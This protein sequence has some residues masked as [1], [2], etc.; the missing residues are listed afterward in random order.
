MLREKIQ[1]EVDGCIHPVAAYMR[2][3]AP[4]GLDPCDCEMHRCIIHEQDGH[5]KRTHGVVACRLCR[6][7]SKS[8]DVPIAALTVYEHYVKSCAIECLVRAALQEA[9]GAGL[10]EDAAL[11]RPSVDGMRLRTLTLQTLV[12]E[13]LRR[14]DS[15]E[16]DR[17]LEA[18]E[19][20]AA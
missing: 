1:C 7:R 4:Y 9:E 20:G 14:A 19:G 16:T 5:E 8:R 6:E 10:H 11:L 18:L 12:L 2:E 15:D 3:R 17:F 13:A